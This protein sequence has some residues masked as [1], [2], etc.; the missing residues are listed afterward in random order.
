ML[1]SRDYTTFPY[2]AEYSVTV[3]MMQVWPNNVKESTTMN[4]TQIF[5]NHSS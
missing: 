3:A 2:A 4:F 5:S 1:H